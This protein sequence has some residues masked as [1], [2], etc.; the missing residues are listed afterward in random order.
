MDHNQIPKYYETEQRRELLDTQVGNQEIAMK[1]H[2]AQQ[3]GHI[4]IRHAHKEISDE[5][6]NRFRELYIDKLTKHSLHEDRVT[7][8][9]DFDFWVDAMLPAALADIYE[10][11][12]EQENQELPEFISP[13]Q[14]SEML[15]GSDAE[16]LRINQELMEK[17]R[18]VTEELGSVTAE[19]SRFMNQLVGMKRELRT[20]NEHRVRLQESYDNLVVTIAMD[21][22]EAAYSHSAT[23]S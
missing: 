15:V 22:T 13:K 14:M 16:L 8:S 5:D 21:Q 4:A 20:V 1:A 12:L 19:N 3:F 7:L 11:K 6:R 2:F 17:L 23:V 9:R 10:A 18:L